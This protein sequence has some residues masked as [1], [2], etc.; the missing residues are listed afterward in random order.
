MQFR[1]A[2]SIAVLAL[3]SGCSVNPVTGKSQ[4][5]MVSGSQELAIGKQQYVPAQQSQGGQYTVSPEVQAYVSKVGKKLAAVSHNPDLPY[6][7]VV[8]NNDVP[9]A[10][11]LPGGKIAINRGLL[12]ELKDEAQLAAVLGHEIVH[13]T[14]RHGATQMTNQ[15]LLGIGTQILGAATQNS[16]FGG[17]ATQGAQLGG[18]MMMARYGQSQELESDAYGIEYMVAA[19]YDAQAAVELQQMFVKMSKNQQSDWVSGLFASHP[20]SQKRVDE[21]QARALAYVSGARNKAGFDRVMA[22]LRRDQAAYQLLEKAT[23]AAAKKDYSGA[24]TLVD[25]A[26]AKQGKEPLFWVTRG[27]LALTDKDYKA[28][29]SAFSKAIQLNPAYFMPYLGRGLSYKAQNQSEAAL[30]D[31]NRSQQLLPSP[32]TAYHLGELYEAKGDAQ[33]AAKNYQMAVQ[34]GGEL[35]QAAN[36]RLQKLY[37]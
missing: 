15:S 32:L 1:I 33:N 27:K 10:W 17:L 31:L 19:G 5:N 25:Q 9:N 2:I 20:P 29:T 36:Q 23:A 35:G 8:L 34:A 14:A 6:E 11:A 12:V 3:S 26:I 30:T 18:S 4:L 21:N 16:G 7:F 22:P 24:M 13:A 37:R 28:S